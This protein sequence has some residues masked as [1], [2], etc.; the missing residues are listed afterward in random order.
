MTSFNYIVVQKSRG[1]RFGGN[2][3]DGMKNQQKHKQE[4]QQFKKPSNSSKV[5]SNNKSKIYIYN[6]INTN[7]SLTPIP[8]NFNC[9]L[10]ICKFVQNKSIYIYICIVTSFL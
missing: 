7:T 2:N 3:L 10:V 1:G 8:S 4:K 6:C 5:S 9:N